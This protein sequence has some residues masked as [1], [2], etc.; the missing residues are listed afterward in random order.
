MKTGTLLQY[1]VNC[2]NN[3]QDGW[4]KTQVLI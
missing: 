2:V 3:M 4:P 1:A